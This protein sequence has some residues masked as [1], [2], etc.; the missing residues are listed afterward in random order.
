[1]NVEYSERLTAAQGIEGKERQGHL[2]FVEH[3]ILSLNR[4]T[5]FA[6]RTNMYKGYMLAKTP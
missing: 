6:I 1:M 3:F 4:S 2:T 5:Q